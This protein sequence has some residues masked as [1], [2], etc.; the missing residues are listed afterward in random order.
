ME[1][2]RIKVTGFDNSKKG[3][4][5]IQIAFEEKITNFDIEVVEKENSENIDNTVSKN[6]IPNAGKKVTMCI[7]ISIGI[8]LALLFKRKA[9]NIQIK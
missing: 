8:C 9:E 5:I 3:K 7:A 4:K 2:E 1:D 6:E